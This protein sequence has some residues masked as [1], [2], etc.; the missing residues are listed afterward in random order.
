[1]IESNN[2]TAPKALIEALARLLRPL[3]KLLIRQQITFPYLSQLLKELYLD[4]A[5]KEFAVDGQ[6]QTDS[7]ITMLTGVHRKDVRR[8]RQGDADNDAKPVKSASLGAQIIAAWLSSPE[9]LDDDGEPRPLHRL[10]AYGEPSFESLV[11]SVS[12]Q[13]LR[14]RPVLDEWLRLGVVETDGQ[15]FVR[16]NKHA[17]VPSADFAEKSFFF[18]KN[19]HD[20]LAAGVHNLLNEQ[21]P[22]FDRSVYYNNLSEESI[23]R[24]QS[25]IEEQAMALLKSVN[26]KARELQ[27][28]DA[29]HNQIPHRFNLGVYFFSEK[30]PGD[31]S[32]KD[33]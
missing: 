19:V 23:Q 31:G 22:L 8:L 16:L 5:E 12:K 11:E 25:L 33:E 4:V 18:G 32:A 20:H 28:K 27:R 30:Q 15:D 2:E 13:D 3:I 17:F 24:L 26:K 10:A 9:Y 7:R 21:P 14:A 6:R 29:K 1:M